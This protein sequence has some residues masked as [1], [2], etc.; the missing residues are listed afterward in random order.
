MK[1]VFLSHSSVDIKWAE[2][3]CI[4]LEK[5]GVKCFLSERDLDRTKDNWPTE[6]I[7]AS[8][9]SD[10][11][12]LLLTRSSAVSNEVLN[13]IANASAK[14]IKIIPLLKENIPV[15]DELMYY[16][17]KYEWI[18]LFDYSEE[19]GK[20][21]LVKRIV[22]SK[23]EKV[24]EPAVK[25]KVKSYVRYEDECFSGINTGGYGAG[26]DK[27]LMQN[28]VAGWSSEDIIIEDV[29]YEEFSFSSIGMPELDEE[30][31]EYCKSAEVK[32]MQLRGNDR[33]RWMVSGLYQNNKIF[34]SLRKTRFSMTGF[35]WSHVRDDSKMQR[36][37]AKHVFDQEEIFYPN[38][39][40]LHLIIETYDEKLLCTKTSVN[41]KNDYAKSIAVTIGEQISEIDFAD[42]ISGNSGFVDQW[43]KR[44]VIEEFGMFSEDYDK[45]V[46]VSSIRVLALSYEG[47]IYNFSLPVYVRLKMDY[48]GFLSYI[49]ATNRNNNEYTDII[50][51]TDKE[52]I[53]ITKAWIDPD[54]RADYHPSSF[55]RALLYAVYKG[56]DKDDGR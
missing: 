41:K 37:M 12:L 29:D 31:K 20:K 7:K 11:I 47:D 53:E 16:I 22:G 4:F 44:S 43:V 30:Y 36:K 19:N 1:K 14:G 51:V 21:L 28:G 54:K 39:F 33:T 6:L 3:I 55:L 18:C 56:A 32:R 9:K 27:C 8:E 52:A 35:W 2:E 25:V 49:N 5:N 24:C 15:R 26:L 50:S 23:G 46:D 13:E 10:C 17:R 38:S 45:Y 34:I 40:C 48:E 42:N